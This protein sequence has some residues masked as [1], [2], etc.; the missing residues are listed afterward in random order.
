MYVVGMPSIT[1]GSMADGS[2]SQQQQ[3]Q[4][5]MGMN[6]GMQTQQGMQAFLVSEVHI[7]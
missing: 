5:Y 4:G 3:Q 1:G 7:M 2:M 6:M